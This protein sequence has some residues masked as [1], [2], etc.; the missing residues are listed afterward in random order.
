M[1]EIE[2]VL[3]V[4]YGGVVFIGTIISI[5]SLYISWKTLKMLDRDMD[6][7]VDSLNTKLDEYDKYVSTTIASHPKIDEKM[8]NK[9]VKETINEKFENAKFAA[10]TPTRSEIS[11][12]P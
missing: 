6:G 1:Q 8:V 10:R 7:F 4:V 9:L 3:F 2:L 11:K 12:R 5:I